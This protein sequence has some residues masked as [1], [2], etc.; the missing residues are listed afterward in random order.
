M[1]E[2]L[3]TRCEEKP[4]QYNLKTLTGLLP[5][6]QRSLKVSKRLRQFQRLGNNPLLLLVVPDL[7]ISREREVLAQRISFEPIVCEDAPE[8]RMS[9]EK[10]TIHVISLALEPVCA[11]E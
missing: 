5:R 3:M 2:S 1:N 8:V 9:R 11:T 6:T 4:C 10:D 7:D